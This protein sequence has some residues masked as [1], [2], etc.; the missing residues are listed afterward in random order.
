MSNWSRR[1]LAALLF[2]PLVVTAGC[3]DYEAGIA[4]TKDM[5]G[6]ASFK[7]TMDLEPFVTGMIQTIG[8]RA[9]GPPPDDMMPMLKQQLS[10]QMG[11]GMIDVAQLKTKL[12]DG[13]TLLDSAQKFD[14]LKLVMSFNF[15]FTDATKLPSISMPMIPRNGPMAAATSQDMKPFE[16]L[17]FVDDGKT[18]TI[19]TKPKPVETPSADPDKS[20]ADAAAA[21]SALKDAKAQL[22]QLGMGDLLKNASMRVAFKFD[23]P[24]TVVEH[25]APKKDGQSYIWEMK[26]ESMGSM[27]SLD[28][29][30]EPPKINLKIKK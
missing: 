20:K 30:P 24:Q 14:E 15:A 5:T 28:K 13:V 2:V 1:L 4:F 19:T 22:E 8:A 25:N 12:P 26:L 3:L 23:V 18:L 7:M 17:Q 10:E 6:K 27:D 29:M 21:A 9:G 16:N 11:N